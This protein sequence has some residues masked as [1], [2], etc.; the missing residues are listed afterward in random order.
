MKDVVE[1]DEDW[2]IKKEATLQELHRLRKFAYKWENDLEDRRRASDAVLNLHELPCAVWALR[3]NLNRLSIALDPI[4]S[5]ASHLEEETQELSRRIMEWWDSTANAAGERDDRLYTFPVP[6]A[7]IVVATKEDWKGA[8]LGLIGHVNAKKKV[9]DKSIFDRWRMMIAAKAPTRK[10]RSFYVKRT[11][12][13]VLMR[14]LSIPTSK[15]L[16]YRER[17]P[18]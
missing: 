7:Q 18:Y 10:V 13:A 12:S 9:I 3:T 8:V 14:W 16:D 17:E 6:T 2:V 11:I 4:S 1:S 15:G 5:D